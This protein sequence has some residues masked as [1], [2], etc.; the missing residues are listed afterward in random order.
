M[1]QETSGIG[2][3]GYQG[4]VIT[5]RAA[6]AKARKAGPAG[7]AARTGG[8]RRSGAAPSAAPTAK[9][10]PTQEVITP[11]K[12]SASAEPMMRAVETDDPIWDGDDADR[13]VMFEGR[14]YD[15]WAPRGTYLNVLL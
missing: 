6:A 12:A 9:A 8:A 14:R 5:S 3:G 2:G 10:A 11:A 1:A 7:S 13:F 15:R 4:P